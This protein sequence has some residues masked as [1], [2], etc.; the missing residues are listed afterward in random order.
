MENVRNDFETQSK[1]TKVKL[2]YGEWLTLESFLP[3]KLDLYLALLDSSFTQIIGNW[4]KQSRGIIGL[5]I[6]S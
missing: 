2:L 5:R 3:L 1:L 6:I 4:S